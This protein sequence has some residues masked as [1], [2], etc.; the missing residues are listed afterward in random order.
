MKTV[1]VAG[2][3]KNDGTFK[4][5]L[6]SDM[7]LRIKNLQKQGD[8]DILLTE[9]PHPMTKVQACEFLLT[10]DV[11][12]PFKAE[13]T[14]AMNKPVVEGKPSTK[15]PQAKAPTKAKEAKV[16]K[17]PKIIV[18]TDEDEDLLIEELKQLVA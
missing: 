17:T 12:Q 16:A 5:R 14:S 18:G 9:L 3:S 10:L 7:V 8:T 13:I 4:V 1:T 6:C 11:F 2:V 15:V